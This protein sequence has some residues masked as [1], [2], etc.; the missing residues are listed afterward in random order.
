MVS[1][2]NLKLNTA[3]YA[4]QMSLPFL[5]IT[6]QEKIRKSKILIIGAG[7]LAH[8]CCQ[9]LASSGIGEIIIYDHDTIEESNLPR[10][11]LFTTAD[12]G[13]EKSFILSEYLNRHYPETKTT[14]YNSRFTNQI[15]NNHLQDISLIINASDNFET[16]KYLN[17][18]SLERNIAWI[19]MGVLKMNGN[20]S[21]FR[22]FLGCFHCL[23]PN[24]QSNEENC[25]LLG[26]LPSTC[27]IISAFVATE[28]L[29]YITL[30][31]KTNINYYYNFNFLV[32]NFKKYF[33]TKNH[34]CL[35]CGHLQIPTLVNS[36]KNNDY[37]IKLEDLSNF[38]ENLCIINFNLSGFPNNLISLNEANELFNY[39]FTNNSE[40]INIFLTQKNITSEKKVLFTCQQGI[41]SKLAS[42][43]FRRMGFAAFY[44]ISN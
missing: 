28:S 9:Y 41:K 35:I 1:E 16:R 13:K 33:W 21:L 34:D 24:I 8:N 30:E 3:R 14:F 2:P 42:E 20:V 7:A 10:Q 25:S 43:Y 17:L 26:I 29:K 4:R 39:I 31:N 6:G 27:G 18:Y 19:D 32:N 44:A 12:I 37:F 22:P 5:G 40:K 11:I 38:T 15:N 23:F 36:Q